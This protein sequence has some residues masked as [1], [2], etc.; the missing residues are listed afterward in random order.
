[1][2]RGPPPRAAALAWESALPRPPR[3]GPIQ[4][5]VGQKSRITQVRGVRA[6][7]VA[8]LEQRIR[9]LSA[10]PSIMLEHAA[11]DLASEKKDLAAAFQVFADACQTRETTPAA[12]ALVT[13]R[14]ARGC[15]TRQL[16]STARRPGRGGVLGAGA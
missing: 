2:G 10:P 9:P 6:R 7:R 3:G 1:M 4:I 11:I 12:I 5:A 15:A 16:L 14:R 8:D 13:S